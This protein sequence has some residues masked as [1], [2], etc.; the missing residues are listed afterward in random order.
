MSFTEI[1][2]T[3]QGVNLKGYGEVKERCLVLGILSFAAPV[4]YPDGDA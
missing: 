2:N 1:Q 4:A 3:G